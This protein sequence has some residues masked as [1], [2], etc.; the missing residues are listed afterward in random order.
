MEEY[1]DLA[2]DYIDCYKLN[3][4]LIYRIASEL[5]EFKYSEDEFKKYKK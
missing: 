4:D 1:L 2:K 3:E 5:S